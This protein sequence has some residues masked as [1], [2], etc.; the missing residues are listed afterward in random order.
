[1]TTL[2]DT[3]ALFALLDEDDVNHEAATEWMAGPGGDPSEILSTH[4]YVVVE[5]LGLVRA[6]LGPSATRVLADAYLPAVS[7]LYVDG[8]LHVSALR[9]HLAAVRRRPSFV[10]WVSFEMM[11]DQGIARAFAFDRDFATEGFELVP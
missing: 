6:R 8:V 10:D 2:V 5:S 3:S 4:S 1:M 11:R 7:I 9:A